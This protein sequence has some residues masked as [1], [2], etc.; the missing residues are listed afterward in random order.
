MTVEK[1]PRIYIT[2]ANEYPRHRKIRGLSD[3][4]FRLHVTLLT[5]AN[6]DRSDGAVEAVDLATKGPKAKKEL[7]DAGLVKD[8]GGGKYELHDYLKH[9]PSAAEIE[10]R[11]EEKRRSGAVGGAKSAHKKWH[12]DR[13]IISPTCKL[14]EAETG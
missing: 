8:L 4:A 3:A 11:I 6:D 5:I 12:V 13:G 7:L 2:L 1:D 14:C 9:Q 10:D